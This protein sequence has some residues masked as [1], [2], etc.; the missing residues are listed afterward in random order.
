M[1]RQG[2]FTLP[3]HD[4]SGVQSLIND[5]KPSC[6]KYWVSSTSPTQVNDWHRVSPDS[7]FIMVDGQVG[8]SSDKYKLEAMTSTELKIIAENHISA[9]KKWK[10]SGY[11]GA[12]MT[13]NEPPIWQ[14]ATY[15]AKLTEYTGYF[16]DAAHRYGLS[17]CIFNF[18]VGW[19]HTWLDGDDWWGEFKPAVDKMADTDFIGLHEYWPS[20]GPLGSWPWLT[21]RHLLCPYDKTI[22][23]S[24]CGLDQATV[25][26]GSNRGWRFFI[27]PEAYVAQLVD[28]H[29][30]VDKRVAGS[31]IFLLDYENNVWDSFDLRYCMNQLRGAN[32]SGPKKY[33]IP[34]QVNL[35]TNPVYLGMTTVDKYTVKFNVKTGTSILSPA[36]GIIYKLDSNSASLNAFYGSYTLSGLT[37]TVKNQAS[38]VMTSEIGKA[39]GSY[40]TVSFR[41]YGIDIGAPEIF[42]RTS[43]DIV[44][45][46]TTLVEQIIGD[47]LQNYVIPLN[48]NAYF[49]KIA[50]TLGY[51]PA[52]PERDIEI[53]GVSYRA[54]VYRHPNIRDKQFIIYA[55]VG[56]WNKYQ[57]FERRN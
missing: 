54:Q 18:S 44:T 57:W 46:P 41:A 34:T 4:P 49:E 23:I 33:V 6:I 39:T 28:Y 30:E 50:S 17:A 11:L 55:P 1:I 38:V 3:R 56:E 42:G 24:E 22:L 35:I 13:F 16:L 26:G 9:Y 8:D 20:S 5:T 10:D 29:R 47:T 21:G 45:T 15:R 32:W 25:E 51:L 19:P 36:T 14:G 48:S 53:N 2:Y 27:S 31:A 40:I 7:K 43:I 37:P 52:S 12:A